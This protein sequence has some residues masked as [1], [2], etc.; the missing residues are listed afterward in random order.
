MTH[1]ALPG[2][3]WPVMVTPYTIDRA[4]DWDG[5]DSVT[6]WYLDNG[7]NGLF[8]NCLSSEMFHLTPEE[9]ITLVARVCAR[10][11]GR[12][13]VVATGNF[14]ARN[15]EQADAVRRMT[16]T[17]AAAVVLLPNLLVEAADPDDLL[18]TRLEALMRATGDAP[19]GLYECPVPYKRILSPELTAWAAA[20]GRFL[21]LKDTT[22]DPAAIRAKCDAAR[23]TPLGI[24]NAYTGAALAS[25]ETGAAGLSPIAA[26]VY[27]ELFS[28]LCAQH[29]AHPQTAA[30]IQRAMRT[31]EPAVCVQYVA[32]AK[33]LMALR[34]VPIRDVCRHMT[35]HI[36]HELCSMHDALLDTIAELD[37]LTAAAATTGEA[38]SIA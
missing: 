14:G 36:D 26:N 22:C 28:W 17:G 15:D 18:K 31:L 20:S 38:R 5:V 30:R 13:P 6:D 32:S 7:A 3:L 16:D 8:A 19:L 11:Q 4:I 2:G 29:H 24:Y 33:R 37:A 34:G 9:R 25:L 12:A 35:L 23:G 21:Y 10:A 27:P 1:S